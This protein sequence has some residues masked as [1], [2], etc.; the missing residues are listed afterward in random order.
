MNSSQ[1]QGARASGASL[2]P[3]QKKKSCTVYDD[4]FEQCLI[5]SGIPPYGGGP[6]PKNLHELNI[7][8]ARRRPSLLESQFS[9]EDF[10]TF[11]RNAPNAYKVIEA[12]SN[13]FPII[14]G[15]SAI[16]SGQKRIFENFTQLNSELSAAKPDFYDGSLPADLDSGVRSDLGNYITPSHELDAPLLPNFFLEIGGRERC[17]RI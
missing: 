12:T 10:Q 11:R 8:L 7:R 9:E 16:I 13:V 15:N 2:G 1:S 17:R 4:N 6:G 14:R 5:D 3:L